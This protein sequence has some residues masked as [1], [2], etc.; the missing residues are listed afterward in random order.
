M[1]MASSVLTETVESAPFRLS[2]FSPSLLHAEADLR[3]K[4]T[5][6][7]AVLCTD[8]AGA[9]VLSLVRCGELA[10][11]TLGKDS[12]LIKRMKYACTGESPQDMDSLLAVL[13]DS[14]RELISVKKEISK[15]SNVSLKI[16]AG[17]FNQGIE[18]QRHLVCDSP[19]AKA[20]K[21]TLELCKPLL[22]HLFGD[23]DSRLDK[24]LEAAKFSRFQSAP[25]RPKAPSYFRS[26]NSQEG[27]DRKK[28]PYRKPSKTPYKPRSSGKANG[29]AAK[30]GEGQQKK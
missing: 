22:T 8:A 26:S 1:K 6:K 17:I 9:C 18:D 11:A 25:Y 21:S 12:P 30:K 20:V 24:A 28:K 19:A 4:K 3:T 15:V 29:P 7:E 27:R 5:F 16:A 14:L 10:H 13:K 2:P 23:D